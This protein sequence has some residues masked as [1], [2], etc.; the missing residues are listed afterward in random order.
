MKVTMEDLRPMSEAPKDG[1]MILAYAK[2]G[3]YFHPVCFKS[4]GH[5]GMLWC[6]DYCTWDNFY[7]GWISYPEMP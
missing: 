1:T 3:K 5:W 7:H 2:E 4:S 6:D